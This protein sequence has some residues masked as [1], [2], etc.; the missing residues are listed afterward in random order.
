MTVGERLRE[1]RRARGMT[2]AALGAAIGTDGQHICKFEGNIFQPRLD[3]LVKLTTI[4]RISLDW[5][6]L[7]K[8]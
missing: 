5:L 2:L 6:V 8:K 7:G 4:L 3:T 1:V